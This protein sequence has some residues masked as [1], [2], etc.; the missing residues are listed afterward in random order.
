MMAS[1]TVAPLE[2]R[3]DPG[4]A[5]VACLLLALVAAA[6]AA[7]TQLAAVVESRIAH[8]AV[9]RERA[10]EAAEYGLREALHDARRATSATRDLPLFFPEGPSDTAEVPG[11]PGD[12]YSYRLYYEGRHDGP[13]AEAAGLVEFHFVA[14]ATGVADGGATDTHVQRFYVLRVSEWT[15][16]ADAP[17]E[18][19]ALEAFE[20]GPWRTSWLQAQAE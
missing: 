20:V 11:A 9:T 2:D 14:E 6:A 16:D 13:A 7:S 17:C 15:G 18:E 12:A 19:C 1:A 10:F 5:L 8:N 3:S 4:F